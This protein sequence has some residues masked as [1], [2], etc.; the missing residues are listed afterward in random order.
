MRTIGDPFII[1]DSVDST[2]IHAMAQAHA[3]LADHGAAFF[4]REQTAGR[5]Q[6]GRHWQSEP[7][8]NVILSVVLHPRDF[9]PADPFPLQAIAALACYDLFNRYAG[10]ETAIKWPNDLYWRDRKAGGILI[11]SSISGEKY[12]HAVVGMGI[13]INQSGFPAELV[14][15]VSLRQITGKEH[16]VE[17]MARELCNH[18]EHRFQQ[19]LEGYEVN[20]LEVYNQRLYARGRTADFCHRGNMVTARVDGVDRQGLLLVHTDQPESWSFGDVDW[21]PGTLR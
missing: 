5:G 11:E 4:A 15:P 16:D 8:V 7:G 19:W 6:R 18:L 13:N 3:G 21:I 17:S 2:N 9:H 14:N 1:L 12:R 20:L 10:D